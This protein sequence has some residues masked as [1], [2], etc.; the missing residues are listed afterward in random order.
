MRQFLSIYTKLNNLEK[1]KFHLIFLFT[2]I[3]I[4]LEML[5]L[6]LIF[7]NNHFSN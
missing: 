6:G 1:H 4:L 5:S 2:V 3:L 7:T